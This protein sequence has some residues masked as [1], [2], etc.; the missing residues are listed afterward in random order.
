MQKIKW[1]KCADGSVTFLVDK[2]Y[3][4]LYNMKYKFNTERTKKMSKKTNKT[5]KLNEQDTQGKLLQDKR[6]RTWNVLLYPD[7]E[8][9]DF[10]EVLA[11]I[12]LNANKYYIQQHLAEDGKKEH[13]HCVLHFENGKTKS[14]LSKSIGVPER[15]L[16]ETVDKRNSIRYLFHLDNPSKT[17]Y[18]IDN[19][20]TN[21]LPTLKK[22]CTNVD[23]GLICCD[24]LDKIDSG[25]TFRE[26]MRWS[27]ENGYYSEFRRNFSI[28]AY[29]KNENNNKK[30]KN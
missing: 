9:Y 4:F 8:D 1:L 12:Q 30:E 6:I 28:L 22:Y 11:T 5:K 29:L 14:A 18:P 24:M 10:A 25:M 21:D 26:L 7:T 17:Q 19:C 16:D 23:E 3:Y 2:L 13:F 27:A 15:F 20:I